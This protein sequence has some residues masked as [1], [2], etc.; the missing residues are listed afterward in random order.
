MS[1]ADNTAISGI[2][3]MNLPEAVRVLVLGDGGQFPVL[4]RETLH[5][6]FPADSDRALSAGLTMLLEI[7]LLERIARGVYVNRAAPGTTERF[8]GWAIEA[9]RPG[10]LNYLSYESALANAGSLSQQPYW[11]TLAT[12]GNPGEYA[13]RYGNIAFRH[14]NRRRGEIVANTV[15]D[16]QGGYMVAHPTMAL[17][18][19]RRAKPALVA[20]VD[21]IAH[22]EVVAEWGPYHAG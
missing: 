22:E 21:E 3:T 7:G 9:L 18:D 1:V 19:L 8:M 14:T 4:R 6:L 15:V 16:E 13:T 17:E 11:Y 2:Y 5:M 10:H 20:S 12:T